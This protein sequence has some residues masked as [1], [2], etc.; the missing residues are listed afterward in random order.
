MAAC[1][2]INY[3]DRCRDGLSDHGVLVGGDCCIEVGW[4]VLFWKE[5]Q[6][7]RKRD[8]MGMGGVDRTQ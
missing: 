8:T 4:S 7:E 5:N 2:M 3:D 6:R 1:A